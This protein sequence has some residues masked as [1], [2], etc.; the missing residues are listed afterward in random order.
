MMFARAKPVFLIA[1]SILLAVIS[2]A[3]ADDRRPG[4]PKKL[5]Q[6]QS[7]DGLSLLTVDKGAVWQLDFGTGGL[8]LLVKLPAELAGYPSARTQMESQGLDWS[9]RKLAGMTEKGFFLADL[10]AGTVRWYQ[11]TEM[12]S[13]LSFSHKADR[14]A[15][16]SNGVLRV[17]DLASGN[18]REIA[19]DT[20]ISRGSVPQW[21]ADDTRLL[22]QTAGK[23][24]WD[25]PRPRI[26]IADLATGQT[27]T[28][29][30]GWTAQW[31]PGPNDITFWASAGSWHATR[32]WTMPATGGERRAWI[33]ADQESGVI[34]YSPDGKYAVLSEGWH[35][36]INYKGFTQGAVYVVRLA[37]QK[38]VNVYGPYALTKEGQPKPLTWAYIKDAPKP[39]K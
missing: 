7:R 38:S 19:K 15:F 16:Q 13:P 6:L 24:P 4:V 32:F 17:M 21:S 22:Y 8:R 5:Q 3:A 18:V 31:G 28:V 9:H 35:W 12:R 2:V 34:H 11:L 29:T 26:M 14:I 23:I 1:S 33:G 37:D 36:D 25:Y 20:D 39:G 27:K 30:D 10:A